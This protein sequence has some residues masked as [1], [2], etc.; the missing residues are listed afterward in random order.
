MARVL[1]SL[2][3]QHKCK[4]K[5]MDLKPKNTI[6]FVV[7]AQFMHAAVLMSKRRIS[8]PWNV[9]ETDWNTSSAATLRSSA[10][11][12]PC[13][14]SHL[15]TLLFFCRG[16]FSVFLFA[17][18]SLL[19]FQHDNQTAPS[20]ISWIVEKWSTSKGW[21]SLGLIC[22]SLWSSLIESF[23]QIFFKVTDIKAYGKV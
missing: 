22:I 10:S 11:L 23:D 2:W 20:W 12:Q 4:P 7:V 8:V 3:A 15:S 16:T 19:L 6:D 17:C 1:G 13:M 21:N 14:S 18:L 5:K 9:S